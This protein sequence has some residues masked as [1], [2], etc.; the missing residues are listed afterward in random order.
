MLY[1]VVFA[2]HAH[3]SKTSSK[4][5]L[6]CVLWCMYE[7]SLN[8]SMHSKVDT[9]TCRWNS[10]A[11]ATGISMSIMLRVMSALMGV[12]LASLVAKQFNA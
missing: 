7:I 5:V 1:A 11:L 2:A 12:A 4:V 6:R 9:C 8:A 10:S 3:A